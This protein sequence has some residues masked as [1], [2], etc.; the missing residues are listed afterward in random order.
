VLG[1]ILDAYDPGVLEE[2]KKRFC[3]P[4]DASG[5]AKTVLKPARTVRSVLEECEAPRIIDYWSLDTEGSEL[6]ILKSFPFQDYRFRILTVEHNWRSARGE[7]RRFLQSR[8]YA[9]AAALGAD[10]CYLDPEL[11]R[12]RAWRSHAWQRRTPRR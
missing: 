4:V 9:H 8:G 5:K 10:D 12:P 2:A 11:V 3:V 1:G 6:A 7:I